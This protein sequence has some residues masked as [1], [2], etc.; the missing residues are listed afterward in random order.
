MTASFAE[1]KLLLFRRLKYILRRPKPPVMPVPFAGPVVVVGSAPVSHK[2]IDF[3]ETFRVITINGSQAVTRKWGITVPDVTLM[4]YRQLDG[5]NTNAVEVRRVLKGERTG[6]L[7]VLLWRKGLASLNEHLKAFDYRYDRVQIV[8]RYERI[9]LVERI[10]GLKVL[11][12]DAISKCSN[13]VIAVL[14]ALLNGATAVII[15]GINPQSTGHVYNQ[16]NLSRLHVE[17]DSEIL[18]TLLRKGYPV[19]TADPEVAKSIGLPLWEGSAR[20]N[21]APV[22]H[23][24]GT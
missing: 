5:T 1:T 18:L 20:S 19:Y 16:E 12:L 17:M 24:R 22:S 10:C 2:P 11:E 8:N 14:F 15:S 9:A 21:S 7:Y 13:G 6:T 3:D 4:Q 23:Y